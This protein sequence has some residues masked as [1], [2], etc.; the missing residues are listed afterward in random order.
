VTRCPV[1]TVAFLRRACLTVPAALAVLCPLRAVLGRGHEGHVVI[2]LVAE[3]FTT[4]AALTRAGDLLDGASI[5]SVA[6]RPT[7]TGETTAR[8]APGTTSTFL[9]DSKSTWRENP[10]RDAKGYKEAVITVGVVL[11]GIMAVLAAYVLSESSV[12]KGFYAASMIPP[13]L[14][15]LAIISDRIQASYETLL[16][17][18]LS[19]LLSFLMLVFGASVMI[20]R[21]RR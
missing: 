16:P 1:P 9:A 4:P 14:F 7:T 5:D 3:H 10:N 2:A 20:V 8:P 21:A 13:A 6:S 12:K 19:L 18:T 11:L 17:L 15:C